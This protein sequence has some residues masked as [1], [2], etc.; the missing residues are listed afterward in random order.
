MDDRKGVRQCTCFLRR[1]VV[2]GDDQ[3][4]TDLPGDSG[5]LDRGDA[6]I[7]RDH[8]LGPV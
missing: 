6:A 8:E 7:H 2:V 5:R 3:V 1:T 4:Q